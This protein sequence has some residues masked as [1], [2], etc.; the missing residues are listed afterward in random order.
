MKQA[1]K[2]IK[3]G[4]KTVWRAGLADTP[5]KK[6]LGIMFKKKFAPLLFDFGQSARLQNSIHSMFCPEFDAVFLDA[7][8]RVTEVRKV[9]PWSFLAPA[10]PAKYLIEVPP[11]EGKRVRPGQRLSW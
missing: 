1:T 7:A 5:A 10:K 9:K 4:R 11:G 8:K 3:L 2:T 6:T